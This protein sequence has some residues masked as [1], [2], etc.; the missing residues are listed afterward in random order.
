MLDFKEPKDYREYLL[1][2]DKQGLSKLIEFYYN[3]TDKDKLNQLFNFAKY[4]RNK[5]YDNRVY[6]RGLI[7]ISS[8]CKNDCYY[9]GLR[10]SNKNANRY[11]LSEDQIIE[12]SIV[13]YNLGFRTFVLQGGENNLYDIARIVKRIKENCP[14]CAVTL[15]VGEKSYEEYKAY[16]Q[17]GAD[18]FLLRHETANEEHYRKLHPKEMKLQNRLDCLKNLREIG[19]QTGAGFMVDSPGQT[20]ETLAEDMLFLKSLDPHMVGIGPFIPQKD[21]PLKDYHNMNID[22]T[23][24][25]LSLVRILIPKSMIPATTALATISEEKRDHALIHSANVVMPNLSPSDHRKDYTLYDNKKSWGNESAEQID[26][27]NKSLQKLNLIG[28]FSRGDYCGFK[29]Q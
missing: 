22:H 21:T 3:T 10:K 8:I 11:F 28:D 26:N 27:I 4:Y 16:K 24:I 9:C 23:L 20:F 5:Y 15:S 13:G 25:M 17:A 1:E 12:T 29:I 18:R 7:E 14:G 19:F 2:L 6:F